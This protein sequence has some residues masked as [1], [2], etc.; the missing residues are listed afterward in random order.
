MQVCLG[1][2]MLLSASMGEGGLTGVSN[3]ASVPLGSERLASLLPPTLLSVSLD[4]TSFILETQVHV[5]VYYLGHH[6]LPLGYGRY[7]YC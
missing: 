4:P 1:T 2:Q 5:H 3:A 6:P 7:F